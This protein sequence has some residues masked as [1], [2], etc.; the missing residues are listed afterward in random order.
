MRRRQNRQFALTRDLASEEAELKRLEHPAIRLLSCDQVFRAWAGH[1]YEILTIIGLQGRL[2]VTDISERLHLKM[3]Q[4]RRDL[5]IL[6]RVGLVEWVR[7]KNTHWFRLTPAFVAHVHEGRVQFWLGL[8]NGD[9][10]GMHREEF[11]ASKRP[12]PPP[13]C[14]IDPQ[15]RANTTASMPGRLHRLYD[16]DVSADP[17]AHAAHKP[18][19]ATSGAKVRQSPG[20]GSASRK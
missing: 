20:S 1:R 12:V 4:V 14:F 16:P 7:E 19:R 13:T 5:Q 10:L 3:S 6:R 15:A 18:G 17:E 11:S 8:P 2:T 9:W